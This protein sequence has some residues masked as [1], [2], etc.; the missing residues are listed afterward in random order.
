MLDRQLLRKEP[1]AVRAGAARKGIEVPIAAF[2]ETDELWRSL[3]LELDTANAEMNEASKSIGALIGQGNSDAAEAMKSK[4]AELKA[5]VKDLGDRER[6]LEARLEEIEMLFPNLPHESVP[7]GKTEQDNVV[8]RMW[9]DK[10]EGERPSHHEICE[11]LGWADFGRAAK[12]SGSGF[13]VYRG[14]GA[15]LHRELIR[16]MLNIQTV[17]RG[18]EEVYP[19]ALV[20]PETLVGTGNLPK[21]EEDLYKVRDDLYL[22]PT[23]EVPV[24]N[25]FRD[26]ILEPWQMPTSLAA[27]TPCFR[28]EAGAAG[29]DT[30]GVLRTHQFEKV[31]LVKFTRPER[32]YEELETLVGDAEEI[33]QRLGLHYRVV[34]LCTGDMGDKGCKTYDL[35]VWAPG[36]GRYLEVSSCTN[37][38]AYQARR[39]NIRF[40]PEPGGKPEFVHT[41]NGS[42][43]AVPRLY[44]ALVETYWDGSEVR[45][46][47]DLD[48]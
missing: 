4:T 10:V 17:E 21:F 6:E 44:A 31:E 13:V 27:F 22:I 33:L 15:R 18:Y 11:Q 48:A 40:R 2:Q 26:E 45:I 32:S 9:G 36:E 42:G 19:P 30:R 43:L 7:D 46:P 41:L 5:K 34:L 16:F 37:F 23:A 35:E 8:V 29:R 28:R 14:K 24:T 1:E 25:L 20:L 3:R 47:A 38:E 39:A 12:I